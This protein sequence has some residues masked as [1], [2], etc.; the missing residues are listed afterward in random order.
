[1]AWKFSGHIF[2]K[3]AIF[4]VFFFKKTNFRSRMPKLSD[5]DWFLLS[6]APA[7]DQFMWERNVN[8]S[9]FLP[10]RVMYKRTVLADISHREVSCESKKEECMCFDAACEDFHL[11]ENS[12]SL[13]DSAV[14]DSSSWNQAFADRDMFFSNSLNHVVITQSKRLILVRWMS[15][16]HNETRVENHTCLENDFKPVSKMY[17]NLHIH[18]VRPTNEDEQL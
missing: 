14:C 13:W 18:R 4:P 8:F 3:F 10:C 12:K 5:R 16:E 11:G 6:F 2:G 9:E 17:F 1:M 7:T 15:Y